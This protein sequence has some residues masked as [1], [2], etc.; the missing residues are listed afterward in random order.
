MSF[1]GG[2]NSSKRVNLK[3]RRAALSQ[4]LHV[5]NQMS[6]LCFNVGQKPADVPVRADVP[7]TCKDLCKQWDAA[8]VAWRKVNGRYDP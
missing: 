1:G 2:E 8:T 5:G 6:N 7:D 3:E 4:L